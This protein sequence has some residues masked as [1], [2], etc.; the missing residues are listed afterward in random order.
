MKG[1]VMQEICCR[2]G[3]K[4]KFHAYFHSNPKFISNALYLICENVAW[5]IAELVIYKRRTFAGHAKQIAV[6]L[7]VH[8]QIH[9]SLKRKPTEMK[10]IQKVRERKNS[11]VIPKSTAVARSPNSIG[12]HANC[13]FEIS[14]PWSDRTGINNK[15]CW[16][17][18]PLFMR[19]HHVEENTTS[20]TATATICLAPNKK[21]Y[22]LW[23]ERE[24]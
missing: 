10:N 15:F 21:K 19:L 16:K 23:R 4:C 12:I 11:N 7:R 1:M 13:R 8:K 24:K 22:L 18:L 5:N 6:L 9:D 17:S 3:W 2:E 14:H 20:G